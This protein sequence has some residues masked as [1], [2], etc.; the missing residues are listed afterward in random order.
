MENKQ[1]IE[2]VESAIASFLEHDSNSLV[3]RL[4]EVNFSV[5]LAF[6]LKLEFKDYDLD[7][8]YVGDA[9]KPNDR[10][11]LTIARNRIKQVNREISE[12]DLYKIRPDIIIHKRGTNDNNLV[13]IEV[14]KDTHPKHEKDYDLIKLEHLTIDYLGNHYNYQLGIALEFGTGDN[15][16]SYKTTIFVNG[17]PI[18][19]KD[20]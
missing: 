18:R 3:R 6:H 13:A 1:I 17:T 5:N 15:T 19:R 10:K 11:A 16:G 14:K 8:E 9:E 2:K 20:L 7:A 4:N 12:D